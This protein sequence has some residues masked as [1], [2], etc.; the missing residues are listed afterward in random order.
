VWYGRGGLLVD[1]AFHAWR[2]EADA[3]TK[4]A[5][6]AHAGPRGFSHFGWRQGVLTSAYDTLLTSKAPGNAAF[7]EMTERGVFS[8]ACTRLMR[9][10]FPVLELFFDA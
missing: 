10:N 4:K 9:S 7:Q 2:V 5:P 1:T 3:G 6:D 8:P